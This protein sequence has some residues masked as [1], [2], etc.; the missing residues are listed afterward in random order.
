MPQFVSTLSGRVLAGIAAA[1]VLLVPAVGGG[2]QQPVPA[3]FVPDEGAF[4]K[5]FLG[6]E[7]LPGLKL[8]FD[9]RRPGTDPKRKR[10]AES[11][12]VYYGE[13]VWSVERDEKGSPASYALAV[14]A[15]GLAGSLPRQGSMVAAPLLVLKGIPTPRFDNVMDLRWVFPDVDAAK[16]YVKDR[17]ATTLSEKMEPVLNAPAIGDESYLF[18]LQVTL[19]KGLREPTHVMFNYVV[20]QGNVVVRL[21]RMQDAGQRPTPLKMGT[22]AHKVAARI[23]ATNARERR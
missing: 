12:G 3:P 18:R 14:G 15:V 7:D 10:F 19:P 23:R 8:E 16:A 11:A 9:G 1:V 22:L 13:M 4:R 20:R 21:F 5:T 6:A 17:L 2:R